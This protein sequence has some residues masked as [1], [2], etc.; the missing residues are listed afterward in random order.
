MAATPKNNQIKNS[1]HMTASLKNM[2]TDVLLAILVKLNRSRR[3]S[4]Y[5]TMPNI[6]AS[7]PPAKSHVGSK[8]IPGKLIKLSLQW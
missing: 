4:A 2:F 8:L 5:A 3:G 7:D 1:P 6:N